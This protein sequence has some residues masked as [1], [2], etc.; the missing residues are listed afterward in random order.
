MW[1]QYT[2][3]DA[4]EKTD[5]SVP[6]GLP[7]PGDGRLPQHEAECHQ[8]HEDGN[9]HDATCHAQKYHHVLLHFGPFLWLFHVRLSS[10]DECGGNIPNWMPQKKR[11]LGHPQAECTQAPQLLACYNDVPLGAF[12]LIKPV[13]NVDEITPL[14]VRQM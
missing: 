9:A 1:W 5:F 12:V 11:I 3:L 13:E 10:M 14:Q 7:E 4:T 2:K 8:D 6:H